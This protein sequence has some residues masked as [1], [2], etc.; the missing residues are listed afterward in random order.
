M[1]CPLQRSILGSRGEQTRPCSREI[2]CWAAI[3]LTGM[4]DA[5][6]FLPCV[7]ETLTLVCALMLSTE[8]LSSAVTRTKP[9]LLV[10]VSRTPKGSTERKDLSPC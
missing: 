5:R 6:T 7:A 1:N 8:C 9:V 3:W 10:P 2:L 4:C